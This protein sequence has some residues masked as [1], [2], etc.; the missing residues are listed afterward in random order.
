MIKSNYHTHVYLCKHAEGLPI[1]YVKK[2]VAL[3]YTD[4]G[5]SDHGPINRPWQDRMTL[6]EFYQ[7]YLPNI[8]KSIQEYGHKIRVHK[9]LEME[10]YPWM[11]KH[12]EMLLQDLD[13]MI[14]GQHYIWHHE[15]EYDIYTKTSKELLHAYKDNVIQAMQTGYFKILAHPDLYCFSYLT[16]DDTCEEVAHAIIQGAIQ[17][18]VF[19][20]LNANG[21]RRGVILNEQLEKTWIYPRLEFWRIVASY[22]EARVIINDDAH[23][24]RHLNDSATKKTIAFAKSLHLTIEE[25][26]K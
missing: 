4:I 13:Y 23:C 22:K 18:N 12:Y 25:Q 3:G 11:H 24:I 14:L 10:Y 20:E 19:L 21:A 9:G 15:K 5:I 8:D 2:A 26:I 6:D 7:I 17:N 16:W 1:D